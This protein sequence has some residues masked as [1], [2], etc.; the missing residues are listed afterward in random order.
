MP[1]RQ[2]A[3]IGAIWEFSCKKK[4]TKKKVACNDFVRVV[5]LSYF[6]FIFFSLFPPL[7]EDFGCPMATTDNDDGF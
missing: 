3:V 1:F 6:I 7:M 5:V 4:G 2:V